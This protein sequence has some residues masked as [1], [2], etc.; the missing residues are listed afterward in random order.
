MINLN[1]LTSTDRRS[2]NLKAVVFTLAAKDDKNPN[3]F[4]TCSQ[5]VP[6]EVWDLLNGYQGIIRNAMEEKLKREL[7]G[8]PDSNKIEFL[9]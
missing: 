3:I 2:V 8:Y 5:S 6:F 9:N 7:E 4:Y 1:S